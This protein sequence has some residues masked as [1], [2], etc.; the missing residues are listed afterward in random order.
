MEIILIVELKIFNY[1]VLIVTHKQIIFQIEKNSSG[2]NPG[3]STKTN[4]KYYESKLS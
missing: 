1:Y 2:S 3:T 4:I